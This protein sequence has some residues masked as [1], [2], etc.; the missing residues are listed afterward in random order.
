MMT[1]EQ[2]QV[3]REKEKMRLDALV[4][5]KEKRFCEYTIF[6]LDEILEG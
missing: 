3:W 6:I 2:L 5:P 4:D 1:P